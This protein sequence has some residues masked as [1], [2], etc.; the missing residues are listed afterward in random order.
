MFGIGMQEMVI[1]GVLFL[2]VFG[3]GKLPLMVR[4]V[5]RFVGEARRAVDDFKRDIA[6]EDFMSEEEIGQ[7]PHEGLDPEE[8]KL[9]EDASH[10]EDAVDTR[11]V[12]PAA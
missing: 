2:I 5:G 12:P 1:I 3:P 6:S 7:E 9:D 8:S 4:D 11:S 10:E